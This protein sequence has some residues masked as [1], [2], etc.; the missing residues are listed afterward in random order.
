MASDLHHT[1]QL[2]TLAAFLPWGNS[3]GAGCVGLAAA[4]ILP[5]IAF[6]STSVIF[7][8]QNAVLGEI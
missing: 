4:K 6:T 1:A 5:F 2:S 8:I 3:T 7:F